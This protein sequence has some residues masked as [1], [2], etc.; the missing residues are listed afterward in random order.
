MK[1]DE[2]IDLLAHERPDRSAPGTVLSGA[3][4]VGALVSFAIMLAW[5]GLRP[6]IA[7]AIWTSPFWMKL[8]YAGATS[9]LAFGLLTRLSRP[10]G[11]LKM[12][13]LIIAAPLLVITAVALEQAAGS[14]A[15]ERLHLVLG[16]SSGVCS[17]RILLLSL[18]ILA[19]MLFALRRLAPVQPGYA[20]ALAG[21]FAG[22]AGTMVYALHCDESAAPFVA[23]WYTLG[24]AAV[25][26]IGGL[27][28]N[29]LLRW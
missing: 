28:G 5:I 23:L 22:A 7:T 29:R 19:A 25:G 11:A 10:T 13:A 18:P 26:A 27:L 12:D 4:A 24:M 1:T 9:A 20:G 21:L 2:L 15:S 3:L 16:N 6:D 14:G 8:A 17:E